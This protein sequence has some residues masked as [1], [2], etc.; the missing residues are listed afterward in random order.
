MY[1][2][3]YGISLPIP[4]MPSTCP[5]PFPTPHPFTRLLYTEHVIPRST[6]TGRHA[7][8]RNG[9]M[10]DTQR[11]ATQI[12]VKVATRNDSQRK[13]ARHA[14]TR[15]TRHAK[16]DTQ[17]H[18]T[19]ICPTRNDTENATRKQTHHATT[20]KTR[21]AKKHNTQRNATQRNIP[22]ICIYIYMF[23]IFFTLCI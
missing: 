22:D 13:Y 15:K 7:T 11:H 6:D 14:T 10:P 2:C 17:R 16:H 23:F 21:H 9:N 19:E 1:I 3:D 12:F 20:R 5:L 4:S 8:T 18:A